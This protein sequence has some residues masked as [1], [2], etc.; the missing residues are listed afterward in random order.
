MQRVQMNA[1]R[2]RS[3][4]ELRRIVKSLAA[5]VAVIN[6]RLSPLAVREK[7][8]I[9]NPATHNDEDI[10]AGARKGAGG[11]WTPFSG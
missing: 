1:N 2:A 9:G 4:E 5:S 11:P 6:D 8:I 7:L 10:E 3:D